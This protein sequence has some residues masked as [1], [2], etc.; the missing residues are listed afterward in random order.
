MHTYYIL[1]SVI[2]SLL[3]LDYLVGGNNDFFSIK[4]RLSIDHRIPTKE[5][6]VKNGILWHCYHYFCTQ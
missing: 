3:D 6:Q 1:L 5:I 2:D 4:L